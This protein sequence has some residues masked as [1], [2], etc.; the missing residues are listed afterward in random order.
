MVSGWEDSIPDAFLVEDLFLAPLVNPKR[1]MTSAIEFAACLRDRDA[2]NARAQQLHQSSQQAQTVEQALARSSARKP[3]VIALVLALAFGLLTA[4]GFQQSAVRA[5]N[6]AQNELARATAL[7]EFLNDDLIS[8]TNPLVA[9]Q[10]P[11]ATLRDV[12]L[13]ARAR[14]AVRFAKQ[15]MTETSIRASLGSL[16]ESID[17]FPKPK[18]K[19]AKH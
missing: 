13:A 16:F 6:L 10:G 2:R 8:R 1:R 3:Y 4:L 15:P 11:E 12:L 19:R 5:R 18:L 9:T 14:V 17:F 7:S